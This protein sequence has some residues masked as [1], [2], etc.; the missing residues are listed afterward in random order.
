LER[1]YEAAS[2]SRALGIPVKPWE[3]ISWPLDDYLA[4]KALA[5]RWIKH[6]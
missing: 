4:A 1:I 2:I 6:T 5:A 3:L